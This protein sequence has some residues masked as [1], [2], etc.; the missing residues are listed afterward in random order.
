MKTYY[1]VKHVYVQYSFQKTRVIKQKSQ[2]QVE[3]LTR[4]PRPQNN[5]LL[6]LL[7]VAYPN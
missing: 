1:F 7:L 4:D 5:S 3:V 6:P 2:C